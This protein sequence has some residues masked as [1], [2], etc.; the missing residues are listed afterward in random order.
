M[1]AVSFVAL[2]TWQYDLRIGTSMQFRPIHLKAFVYNM[3]RCRK[4]MS[5]RLRLLPSASSKFTS[6]E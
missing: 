3:D 6:N 5:S 2:H 4:N 1:P